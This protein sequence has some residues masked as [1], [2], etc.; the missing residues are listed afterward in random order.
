MCAVDFNSEYFK[1]LPKWKKKEIVIEEFKK[2]KNDFVYFVENYARIRHPKS[3]IIKPK[4]FDYQYDV[5]VPLSKALIS[6]T[7]EQYIK[8]ISKFRPKFN[9]F[10]WLRELIEYNIEMLKYVPDEFHYFYRITYNNPYYW[11]YADTIILKS[12]QTGL[13]TGSQLLNLWDINF[14]P[15]KLHLVIS[16]RDNEAKKYL[17]D[18][19]KMYEL[20]PAPLRAKKLKSND[21][22]LYISLRDRDL[23]SGIQA[24]APSPDAGRSFS[25]NMVVLDE[26]AMYKNAEEVFTAVSM[27][28]STGG[29]MLII[30]TPKGVGNMY[31]KLWQESKKFFSTYYIPNNPIKND[32]NKNKDNDIHNIIKKIHE[33]LDKFSKIK[34]ED[35][36]KDNSVVNPSLLLEN[37]SSEILENLKKLE[38]EFENKQVVNKPLTDSE[39]KHIIKNLEFGVF[40][41]FVAHWTQLPLEEFKRR[42]FDTPI[43][44]YKFMSNKLRIEGGERLVAQELD[45]SFELS[46]ETFIPM[47][48]IKYLK[49]KVF[50]LEEQNTQNQELAKLVN[51]ILIKYDTENIFNGLK[52][53][54]PPKKNAIYLLGVDVSEGIGKDYSVITI[55]KVYDENEFNNNINTIEINGEKTYVPQIVGY[56]SNNKITPQ[57]L[58]K[59]IV[60]IGELY[61]YAFINFEKN[62]PGLVV[63][64]ELIESNKY[65]YPHYLIMNR[66]NPSNNKFIKGEK[67]WRTTKTTKAFMESQLKSFLMSYYQ[68]IKLPEIYLDEMIIY[69]EN[70][71]TD[72]HVLS[73][74][75]G[76]V[77]YKLLDKYL[78]FLQSTEYKENFLVILKELEKRQNINYL[79]EEEKEKLNKTSNEEQQQTYFNF[80]NTNNIDDID[81]IDYTSLVQSSELEDQDYNTLEN[82]LNEIILTNDET[83]LNN[84]STIENIENTTEKENENSFLAKYIQN[85]L[86]DKIQNENISGVSTIL[87]KIEDSLKKH[88]INPHDPSIRYTIDTHLQKLKNRRNISQDEIIEIVKDIVEVILSKNDDFEVF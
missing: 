13:S 77:G 69:Y 1:S 7:R 64:S 33:S 42:G 75:L 15:N 45:L 76:I 17:G 32:I 44:W 72:D 4:L 31:Y 11:F 43:E 79:S 65:D 6:K 36:D 39:I 70:T 80:D 19:R 85:K 5:L 20:L 67:G 68:Y 37:Y 41:P 38:K 8:E 82:P 27:A 12:R 73:L 52:L 24:L 26:F 61:N 71:G 29:I 22:E 28:L 88:G 51:E 47:D 54:E 56:Y 81:I 35:N 25:P 57:K 23:L 2:C 62:N 59:V 53:Y 48:I 86:K 87:L 9:Y 58:T 55:L 46:G 83:E 50:E 49:K 34:N 21:H 66:Y 40:K 16:Q 18:V 14:H 10:K 78:E 30:S 3:G 74:M 84:H 60:S 63:L